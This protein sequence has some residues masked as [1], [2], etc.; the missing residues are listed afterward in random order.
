MVVQSNPQVYV[1]GH[2]ACKNAAVGAIRPDPHAPLYLGDPWYAPYTVRSAGSAG[3][4]DRPL[5]ASAHRLW[6][7]C[8][9]LSV[10]DVDLQPWLLRYAPA[11]GQVANLWYIPNHALTSAQLKYYKDMEKSCAL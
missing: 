1:D 8:C 7:P 5:C 2:L 10:V 11:I 6:I 3:R 4:S 9:L